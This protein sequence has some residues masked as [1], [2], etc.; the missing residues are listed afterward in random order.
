MTKTKVKNAEY[1]RA[2]YLQAKAREQ[3]SFITREA[4]W[5]ETS[6]EEEEE[7]AANLCLMASSQASTSKVSSPT[8]IEEVFDFYDSSITNEECR[9]ALSEMTL[10]LYKALEKAKLLKK[11]KRHHSRETEFMFD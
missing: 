1:Y 5:V 7:N 10:D 3:K 9:E 11:T 4:D 2:K 8:S 6:S